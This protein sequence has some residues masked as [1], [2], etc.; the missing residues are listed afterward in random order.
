VVVER[1]QTPEEAPVKRL[2][3]MTLA[4]VAASAPVRAQVRTD[5]AAIAR[6][7]EIVRARMDSFPGLAVAVAVD[8][9][10]VWSE[11]FGWADLEQH[12][13]V[14]PATEFRIGSI[15]KSLTSAA[16]GLLVQEGKLD[17]DAPVQRYV[18][19]F[20]V[21]PWPIT[22]RQVAGHLAGIRHYRGDEFLLYRHYNSVLES[23]DIFKN[24]SLLFQPGTKFSYSSY[25][26]NLISAVIEGASADD[27]LRFMRTR[28]IE[29]LHL[30]HTMP[31]FLDSIVPGR[32][33]YY[34][35]SGGRWVNAPA[36]DNSYKWAGGG[37]LS[38]AE[39]LVTYGS[40]LLRPGFLTAE[41]LQ[42]LFTSQRTTAGAETGYGIGW[43]VARNPRGEWTYSHGGGS[44]GGTSFLVIYPARKLVMAIVTNM[45][46]AHLRRLPQDLAGA[47]LGN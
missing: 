23:L 45:T 26:W 35:R 17:L 16:V 14:T 31:D 10:M 37:F 25:G 33:R 18:P 24:D 27:Y 22:V 36:V 38:T 47:F 15:S 39:D 41:S 43:F 21:K 12:V 42:L 1:A 5:S 40:A 4:L 19:S 20:P 46:D 2:A 11:G 32:T 29:P 6:A 13:P 34:G 7:R 3:L 28:V 44:V 9:R 8:G 30:A